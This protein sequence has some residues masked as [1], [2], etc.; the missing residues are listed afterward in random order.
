MAGTSEYVSKLI[1]IMSDQP[2]HSFSDVTR[3][4]EEL[5]GE[6]VEASVFGLAS[7][8]APLVSLSGVIR[9]IESDQTFPAELEEH[10]GDEAVSFSFGQDDQNELMLWPDR[11]VAATRIEFPPQ[12]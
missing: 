11:F 6:L 5:T 9:K 7:D 10:F 12:I 1:R 2:F 4:I 3:A 8:A